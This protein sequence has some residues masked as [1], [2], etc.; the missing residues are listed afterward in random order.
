MAHSDNNALQFRLSF[1][2]IFHSYL[3]NCDIIIIE[4]CDK[5]HFRYKSLIDESYI[6]YW[7]RL[8]ILLVSY[9]L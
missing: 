3:T 8:S 2:R 6:N 4:A 9:K 1:Q 5:L 7:P